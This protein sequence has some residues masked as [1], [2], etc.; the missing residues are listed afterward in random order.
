M[1]SLLASL[2]GG[3][4]SRLV[5]VAAFVAVS[6]AAA[7]ALRR[8]AVASKDTTRRG[9]STVVVSSQARVDACISEIVRGG[10]SSLYIILDFD[11]TMSLYWD[12]SRTCRAPSSHGILERGRS[13]AFRSTAEALTQLYFPIEID[14]SLST[15]QKLPHMVEWYDRVHS[16]F[17]ADGLSRG[18]IER[19][20]AG[21]GVVLR[22]G[23]IET[24]AWCARHGV[25]LIVM[26]AGLDDVIAEVLRQRL[27]PEPLPPTLHIVSNTMRFDHAGAVVGFSEPVLHMFNKTGAS[28]P[29]ALAEELRRRPNAIVVGDS[30]GDATMADGLGHSAVLKIGLL[31]DNIEALLAR[32]RSLFDVLILDDGSLSPLVDILRRVAPA[33]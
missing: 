15:A 9:T 8:L 4:K 33:E 26:S 6:L 21:S 27:S 10:P 5:G 32:Y 31:N 17:V 13:A 24:I 14:P 2:L 7:R 29:S 12:A 28:I 11:R 23:V 25:P 18:D 20:V 3:S 22:E 30:P 1:A 19:A 16:A